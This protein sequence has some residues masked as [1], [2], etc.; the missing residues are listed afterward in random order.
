MNRIVKSFDDFKIF[1]VDEGEI[2]PTELETVIAN[3]GSYVLINQILFYH[4]I[5]EKLTKLGN[6]SLPA[7]QVDNNFED[8]NKIFNLI[9]EID[10]DPIYSID[11][12]SFLTPESLNAIQSSIRK[13]KEMGLER[14]QHDFLG[15]IYH[16]FIPPRTRKKL[17]AF[18]TNPKAAEILAILSIKTESETILDPACGSGTLLASA[19]R[20]KVALMGES[21]NLALQKKKQ[22][23]LEDDLSGIDVMPFSAHLAAINLSLL[24]PNLGIKGIKIGVDDFLQLD[25]GSEVG[26]RGAQKPFKLEE[27]DTI[28]M[29]PPFTHK[30]RLTKQMKSPISNRTWKNLE[31]LHYWSYFMIHAPNILKEQGTMGAILPLGFL[32]LKDGDLVRDLLLE[33]GYRVKYFVKSM[34]DIAFSESAKFRDYLIIMDNDRARNHVGFV[35]ILN[36]IKEMSLDDARRLGE[37]II[38]IEPGNDYENESVSLLWKEFNEIPIEGGLWKSVE[39]NDPIGRQL[40]ELYHRIIEVNPMLTRLGE[41]ISDE[42]LTYFSPEKLRSGVRHAIFIGREEATRSKLLLIEEND[43]QLIS[44]LRKS[45]LKIKIPKKSVIPGLK[46]GS[47]VS[48][49]NIRGQDFIVKENFQG[50]KEIEQF[51]NTSVDFE[52]L[53]KEIDRIK[54]KLALNRRFDFTAEGFR[55]FCFYSEDQ[56]VT[57][58]NLW[59]IGL[60]N[61]EVARILALWFNSTPALIELIFVR[62]K[63][64]RGSYS[65]IDKYK[66]IDF[67]VLNHSLLEDET[68][69]NLLDIFQKV[70]RQELPSLYQQIASQNEVRMQIDTAILKA[71][72]FPEGEIQAILPKLYSVLKL[73]FDELR[74]VM[75]KKKSLKHSSAESN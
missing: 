52:I 60:E 23:F 46:T 31:K 43:D 36:T 70:S 6:K 53:R 49:I 13:I 51:F 25:L 3:L 26:G 44:S 47:Y 5:S 15:Q 29:N 45:S 72:G 61:D 18:F 37:T 42:S 54:G 62:R 7:L 69:S 71:I 39:F 65:Q 32:A 4:I 41:I 55:N 56:L 17:A 40:Q 35:Y 11:I 27:V 58:E 14:L 24:S 19:Y 16:N 8:L 12:L 10:Y 28:L 66:L 21:N 20:R 30:R 34:K 1:L 75:S 73:K 50:F 48:C 38:S 64:T 68:R 74:Y 2:Q 9:H 57:T 59:T 63:E 22:N 33:K 67:P